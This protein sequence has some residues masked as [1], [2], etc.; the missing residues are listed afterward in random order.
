MSRVGK[1]ASQSSSVGTARPSPNSAKNTLRFTGPAA[2]AL[3]SG[4]LN[5]IS[6]ATSSGSTPPMMNTIRQ[7]KSGGMFAVKSA[8]VAPPIGMPQNIAAAVEARRSGGEISAATA[9]MFGIAPPKPRPA[10]KRAAKIVL[11]S[12]AAA[13]ASV[14]RPNVSTDATKTGLR[15]NL[16]ASQPPAVAPSTRPTLLIEKIQPIWSGCSSSARASLRA[17]TPTAWI[18]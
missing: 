14:K 10:R 11:K 2:S 17:T 6:G 4:N 1:N 3:V 7:S 8:L 15:P 5:Q 13:V 12:V 9:I 16:S 18:S